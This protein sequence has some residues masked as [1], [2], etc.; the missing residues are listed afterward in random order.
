MPYIDFVAK[1]DRLSLWYTTNTRN[2]A[3]GDFDP[4]KPVVVMLHPLFLDSTWLINQFEDP[5]LTERYNLLAVDLRCSGRSHARPSPAHDTWVDAAD[6]AL[7]LMALGLPP[8]HILAIENISVNAALRLAALFPELCQSLTLV[9]VPP[10]TEL[11]WVFET[12]GELLSLWCH[13]Q[14][15]DEYEHALLEMTTYFLEKDPS[16]DLKDELIAY[17][18][19]QYPPWRRSRVYEL[20]HCVL[21]RTPLSETVLACITQPTLIIQSDKTDINPIKYADRLASYLV[22]VE[23]KARV[24]TIKGSPEYV[25][26]VPTCATIVNR[27]F[28]EFLSRQPRPHSPI[29]LNSVTAADRRARLQEAL[30]KLADL[31]DDTSIAVR[32]PMSSL[33]FSCV[34]PEVLQNQHDVLRRQMLDEHLAFSPLGM[35][36]RP[37][38]R[39][40][41]RYNDHWFQAEKD[42]DHYKPMHLNKE[43]KLKALENLVTQTENQSHTSGKDGGYLSAQEP[44]SSEIARTGRLRRSTISKHVVEKATIGG[45][46]GGFAPTII[47]NTLHMSKLRF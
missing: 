32:D 34:S 35:D 6:L 14:D 42:E 7:A 46:G 19:S 36:G 47:S 12:Y 10:P 39:F 28:A 40:S 13:P 30:I 1:D 31:V 22:N 29:R 38:R 15:L 18:T 4:E 33:S 9:N 37:C 24:H 16:A 21:N 45:S 3:V 26:V 5:R 17:W 20:F 44:V 23:G 43:E 27:V 2:G 11:E 8:A 41:E 25:T